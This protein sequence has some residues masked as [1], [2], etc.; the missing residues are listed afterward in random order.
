MYTLYSQNE[1]LKLKK[2]IKAFEPYILQ[3]DFF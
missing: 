2:V 1:S 3:S